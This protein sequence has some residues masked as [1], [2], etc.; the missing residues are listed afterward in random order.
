VDTA[1]NAYV[2]DSYNH[3]I[4]KITPTGDVSTLAGSIESAGAGAPTRFRSACGA[5]VDADGNVYVADTTAHTIHKVTPAGEVTTLAGSSLSYGSADGTGSAA[6]F[7]YPSGVALDASGNVYVADR[8][9][10]TIRKITPAGEVT[11]LA[12]SAGNGG[13]ADGTGST[14]RFYSP[15]DVAVDSDGNVYVADSDKHTIRKVTPAGVVTTLAGLAGTSGSTDGTGNAARFYYPR[16]LGVDNDGNVYVADTYNH[17][18]R[19]V[20]PAGVVTTVAGLAGTSG[21]ADGT[22]NAARFYRPYDVSVDTNGNLYVS[23]ASNYT[24]RKITPAG[25]VTTLAGLAGVAGS[26]NGTGPAARF[27]GPCNS[28]VDQNGILYVS[29]YN[30]IRKG[31]A[32]IA[33]A[34]TIDQATGITGD[35]RQLDTAPQTATSW[36]WSIIRRPCGSTANLSST[37]LRNPTFTPDARGLYTFRL[38]ATDAL[39]TLAITTVDLRV[40]STIV[41]SATGGGFIIP[42]GTFYITHGEWKGFT[43]TAFPYNQLTDV[44]IDGV[45]VGTVTNYTFLDVTA[46]HTITAIFAPVSRTTLMTATTFAGPAESPGALDGTGNA[47]RFNSPRNVAVDA[48]GNLY[49]ADSQNHTIR[50][51]SPSGA[52][53]TLAGLAGSSGSADGTG[54]VARFNNPYDVAV[55]SG[56]N[57]YVADRGNHTVR[58]IGPTGVVTTLTG[59]AGTSGTADG[60]GS[61]AR[62]YNPSGVAVDA[63][64]IVYV[65]DTGNHTIRK[66]TPAGEVTTF[67]GSAG[68]SGGADGTGTAASFH[69]PYGLD[70]GT[71]GSVYVASMYTI[72]KITPA[73]EVTTLAGSYG[74]FGSS[75]GNGAAARFRSPGDVAVDSGGNLYVADSSNCTIRKVTPAGDVTTLAGS[76]GIYGKADGAGST[77]RFSAPCGV[78]VAASSG[79]IFVADTGN[80]TVRMVTPAG[81]TSTF[82]GL[83]GGGGREDGT[84]VTARFSGPSGVFVDAGGN[85][86]VADRNRHTI[87]RITA[88]GAVTTLAGLAGSSGSTDGAGDTARF[89]APSGVT[90]DGNGILYVADYENHTIRKVT[91]AGVVTTLAGLAGNPGGSDGT[92]NASRFYRPSALA[93][94]PDGNIYVADRDNHTIRKVTPAGAVTTLAGLA[95]TSGSANGTGNAARF[96]YPCGV[97]TD[98]DNNV[99]VADTGNNAVRKITPAGEVTTL[100]GNTIGGGFGF[101][102]DIG[103]NARFTAP[104]GVTVD[105]DGNVYVADCYNCTIRKISPAGAVTTVAGHPQS[106]SFVDGT[107][108]T[109]RFF[110]QRWDNLPGA[111]AADSAGNVYV[112]D[113]F[114]QSIRKCVPALADVATIDQASCAVGALRQLDTAPQTAT[115]WQWTVI[116]RPSGSTAAFSSSTARNPTFR[117]DVADLFTFRLVA[118]DA[119]GKAS[120]STVSLTATAGPANTV[121][122][123]AG[124]GGSINPSGAVVVAEHEDCTFTITSEAGHVI[125]DV[126]VDGASVGPVATYTFTNVTAGHTVAATFAHHPLVSSFSPDNPVTVPV[127]A[128]QDFSVEAWDEDGDTL[129]YAWT[130]DGENVPVAVDTMGYS[131]VGADIGAHTIVV[132]ISDGHGGSASLTWNV[133]VPNTVPVANAQSVE[134]DEETAKAI[135]LAATDPDGQALT[136]TVVSAPAHGTLSGT[137]PALT[138]TPAARYWG[139]DSFTFKANDGQADSNV[140]T[141][142]I[143]VVPAEGSVAGTGANS[144]GQ[145]GDGTKTARRLPVAAVGASDVIAVSAGQSHTLALKSDGT[146]LAW[147]ANASGQLGD[148]T[149]T[150]RLTPVAVPGL[151]GAVAVAAG[152]SHSLALLSDGTVMAWGSNGKGQL[153]D[154]TTTTRK[155]PVAVPGLAGVTAVAAG[156]THSLALTSGGAVLAWGSNAK[157]QLG[158]GTVTTRKTPVAVSGLG[159]GV[160]SIAAGLNHS[161]AVTTAGAALAWGDNASAQLGDGTTTV[162]KTPVAVSGLGSGVNMLAGGGTH[163]L[164][165]LSDGTV[166][167][168]GRNSG[169][170]LGDGTTTTRKTPVAATGVGGAM[171]VAAGSAH[172]VA[173]LSD[174]T[175]KAWGSNAKGQLGDG[176]VTTRKT[177]VTMAGVA[178]AADAAA[179][180]SQ[181]IVV[182]GS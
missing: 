109:T 62:F 42:S 83:A 143:T 32:C 126:L 21:S 30:S 20:T 172:S 119:A 169:G 50:K 53:T 99:Y 69:A 16:G 146:V 145:L 114:N 110:L 138:Y 130:L 80:H 9:N 163:S 105:S 121:T 26:M 57:V 125:S 124:A 168:W 23:D 88:A 85:A 90:A 135:T 177:A 73:G 84:T 157:G 151:S 25:E 136:Y 170:Q 104:G 15:W 61:E 65:A 156:G 141:V 116:R 103:S 17:T 176:T 102:D 117:P 56:G 106:S 98:L 174:G 18:I 164:A 1:G 43:I 37:T 79:T 167:A 92:G 171:S 149:T 107:G 131:P 160:G 48:G 89:N 4:R 75:D 93:V 63:D 95:G 82:A 66:I 54:S 139:A 27:F 140:A 3:M 46:N 76:A 41:A 154:G 77:A 101:E 19:K 68:N 142:T 40:G 148:G 127:G 87:R 24:M 120:I 71:D 44:L 166:R 29:D 152:G 150:M 51:I 122:A 39:G 35:P 7:Y 12:G 28:T 72:R 2:A 147:G 133:T 181:T 55:D 97:A 100:A 60:L 175:V 132:T 162:R 34:A 33:D 58:K 31:T 123:S 144:S 6:R 13:T 158:D 14:A 78:A 94:G 45:S 64:G 159:S 153:G 173:R 86:Y 161:L 96:R 59:A 38:R 91:P 118:T 67:A 108:D 178:G 22:G 182:T 113:T 128:T 49:V 8:Y 112:A 180:G 129:S 10:Y 179:G 70:A 11:T 165:L 74:N 115:A 52:V 155:S 137:A 5:A 47:A 134:V 111:V 81:E 36:Q